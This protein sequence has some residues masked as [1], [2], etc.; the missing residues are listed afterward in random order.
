M[1]TLQ[2]TANRGSVST[3]YDI[4][5][6]LKL[7]RANSEQI[8]VTNSSQSGNRKTW[9]FSTWI[10][11]TEISYNGAFGVNALFYAASS[12][13]QINSSD[14]IVIALYASLTRQFYNFSSI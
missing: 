3:G 7:E 13:M 2:R 9:T 14:K 12:G 4:D 8:V 11:R 6:S 5:N 10:K 1:E